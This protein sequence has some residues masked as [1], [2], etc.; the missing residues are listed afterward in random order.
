MAEG[1]RRRQ[2]DPEFDKRVRE[3]TERIGKESPINLRGRNWS[4]DTFMQAGIEN[5]VIE[6]PAGLLD[7]A[8]YLLVSKIAA[9]FWGEIKE[10]RQ[11]NARLKTL[12]RNGTAPFNAADIRYI[13]TLNTYGLRPEDIARLYD[14]ETQV[15]REV[16]HGQARF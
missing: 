6:P 8:K 16:L 13:E 2:R 7:K 12:M 11:E 3:V 10:L 5:T 9:P 4:L 15:I 14:V 1:P